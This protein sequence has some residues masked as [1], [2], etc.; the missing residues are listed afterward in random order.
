[1]TM[2]RYKFPP[3]LGP[4]SSHPVGSKK[5]AECL[6]NE[7]EYRVERAEKN[8]VENLI[9]LINLAITA[10][11]PPWEVWPEPPCG[12]VDDYFFLCTGLNYNQLLTLITVYKKDHKLARSLD[13]ARAEEQAITMKLGGDHTSSGLKSNRDVVT[14]ASRNDGRGN[15]KA[16]LL[17]RMARESPDILKRWENG[18]FK[19]VRAAA[20]AAGIPRLTRTSHA[21]SSWNQMTD[22]E[23]NEFL[24]YIEDDTTQNKS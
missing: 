23:K 22:D 9:P 8:G 13:V 21:R 14:V 3:M 11:T 15:S 17:R 2:E 24:R 1:M 18:E 10:K 5:W 20:D 6:G 7:L 16:Y 12:T 19:S 4:A